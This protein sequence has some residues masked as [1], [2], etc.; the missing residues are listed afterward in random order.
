VTRSS[1]ESSVELLIKR[2]DTA[3]I[4]TPREELKIKN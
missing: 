4:K 3:R 1:V 2:E